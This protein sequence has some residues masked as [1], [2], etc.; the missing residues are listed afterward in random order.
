MSDDVRF[1]ESHEWVRREGDLFVVGITDY[2]V[3]QLGDV[4]YVE[5]PQPGASVEAG[6]TFGDIESVKAV[7]D[8]FSP[9]SGEVVEANDELQQ[10]PEM[11]NEDPTGTGWMLK[12]R[13]SDTGEFERLMT[14]EQYQ[15]HV[16]EQ[17]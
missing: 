5:L 8:L 4:V 6:G 9:I 11:V 3:E 10:R 13:A 15:Q 2:A 16:A 17:H 14:S 1:S 12:L 7:S